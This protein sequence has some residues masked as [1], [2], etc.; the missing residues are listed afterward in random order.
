MSSSKNTPT[1]V[2][3]PDGTYYRVEI[4]KPGRGVMHVLEVVGGVVV[5][6]TAAPESHSDVARHQATA[7]LIGGGR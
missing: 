6:H 7:A 5:R 2:Q 1:P 3:V 4:P